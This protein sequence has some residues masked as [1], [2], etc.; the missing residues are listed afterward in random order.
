[1][2]APQQLMRCDVQREAGI[3]FVIGEDTV[4]RHFFVLTALAVAAFAVLAA[5]STRADEPNEAQAAQATKDPNYRWYNGQWWYW[6][7]QQKHWMVW[8]GSQWTRYDQAQ[9]NR[10]GV[11][12]FSY[13][14]GGDQGGA[15][16]GGGVQRMFGTPR[17]SNNQIIGS[18]GIRGAGSKVIGNY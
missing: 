11:R 14:E 10:G 9:A 8:N 17:S 1:M 15:Y 2:F 5:D 16:Y 18:Y 6:M 12:S 4:M 7:P 13:Q 3:F